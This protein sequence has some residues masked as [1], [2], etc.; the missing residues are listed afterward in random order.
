MIHFDYKAYM[1]FIKIKT[2]HVLHKLSF[3]Y[4]IPH[5]SHRL[6]GHVI[7]ELLLCFALLYSEITSF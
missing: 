5:K 2:I 1:H 4:T 3:H 7:Q 6:I